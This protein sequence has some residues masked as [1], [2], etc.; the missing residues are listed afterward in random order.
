LSCSGRNLNSIGDLNFTEDGDPIDTVEF[1][2][3]TIPDSIKSVKLYIETSGSMNGFFHSGNATKFKKTVWS[4]F[5]GLSPFSNNQVYLLSNNGS[6]SNSVDLNTFRNHMNSGRFVSNA[7]TKVPDMLNTIL[8]SLDVSKGEIAVLVSDMKY[9]PTGQS[10]IESLISQYQVDIRNIR[11]RFQY[12]SIAFVCATSEYASNNGNIKEY[13]SPYYFMIFGNSEDVVALRN[14]ISTW[15]ESNDAY[16]ESGDLGVDYKTPLYELKEC[17]NLIN[18]TIYP[19]NVLYGYD[20]SYSDTC[21]FVLRVNLKSYPWNI[22][23]QEVLDSCITVNTLYGSPIEVKLLDFKDDHH[24]ERT[25]ERMSYADYLI[26]VYDFPLDDEVVEW[27]YNVN[28]FDTNYNSTF[29]DISKNAL[30]E[31]DLSRSYSFDK[32]LEG[33]FNGELN[34]ISNKPIKILLSSKDSE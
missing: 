17:K 4:V 30:G 11:A 20:K 18:H 8:S 1:C 26:K 15:V 34:R 25:F 9:S 33:C 29:I 3:P 13:R 12:I 27:T 7:S 19:N 5:T 21:S 10:N 14:Y 16:I 6:V 28:K 24:Y 22:V 31:S 23:S 32:F 2:V